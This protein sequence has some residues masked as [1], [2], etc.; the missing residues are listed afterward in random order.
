M[1]RVIAFV[2]GSLG[3]QAL[4]LLTPHL[5]GVVVHAPARQ[6]AA[7]ELVH[8]IPSGIPVWQQV[9]GEALAA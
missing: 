3:V 6:R 5:V 8:A 9:D 2:N 1:P 4:R 7:D